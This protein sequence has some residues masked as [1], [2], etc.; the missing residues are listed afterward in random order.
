MNEKDYEKL[1]F[2][3][4]RLAAAELACSEASARMEQRD[5]LYQGQRE[6]APVTETDVR[7]DGSRRQAAHVHNIVAENIES[8]VDNS[9]PQPRVTACRAQDAD[10]ARL[11]ENMLRNEL[12][13][14]PFE[15][16]NDFM[17]RT[18]PIQGGGFWLVEWDNR[19][20]THST[21]GDVTVSALHPLQVIPQDGV[22]TGVE[23]MDYIFLRL[24]QT[25]AS[26]RQRYGV[27]PQDNGSSDGT[28][29]EVLYQYIAFYRNAHGGIGRYSWAED[30][31]LEDLEDYQCRLQRQ[32]SSCGAICRDEAEC[33]VCGGTD[34]AKR[35]QMWEALYEAHTCASGKVIPGAQAITDAD[36]TVRLHPTRIPCYQPDRYPLVL[37]KNVSSYGRLLGDSDVDKIADLQNT[38]NRMDMKILDRIIKAGTRITLPDRA[39][40]RVDAEDGEKWYIGSAA[41]KAMI[42]VYDF[43]GDLEYELYWRNTVYQ[44]ARFVLGITDSYQGR[45]DNTAISGKAKE[46]AAAQSAGRLESKRIMKQAAYARLFELMFRFRL[47]YA[48][49]PRPVVSR[50]GSGKNR[51]SHFDRFEFLEQDD[52]GEWYWNDQFLFSCDPSATLASNR[53]AMWQE[54]TAHLQAGAFGDPAQPETLVRY[55]SC[56]ER[57]NY[58]GAAEVLAQL[59]QQPTVPNAPSGTERG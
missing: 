53:S 3:Q 35:P 51:Y 15:E 46:F 48:D 43:K 29:A 34:F 36:G 4:E 19:I 44:Q 17:E 28:E 6:I 30:V 41:D 37:Q 45:T 47:A 20:H 16:L 33:P 2:W 7:R 58:P 42:G 40:F 52:A 11:I 9:I 27:A 57:L 13:R 12:D 24:P 26:L 18:V 59:E 25:R 49:E 38:L 31:V 10:K 14:L 1:R 39:D 8:E 50:D 56:M 23:D 21:V 54:T 22:F 5:R 55:W 32:C